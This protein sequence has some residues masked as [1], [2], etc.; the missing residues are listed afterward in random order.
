MRTKRLKKEDFLEELE[1]VIEGE[2]GR[3]ILLGDFKEN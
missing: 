2:N 1:G 3:L